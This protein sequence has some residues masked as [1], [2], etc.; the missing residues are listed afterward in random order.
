MLRHDRGGLD[1]NNLEGSLAPIVYKSTWLPLLYDTRNRII[2]KTLHFGQRLQK[3]TVTHR[4]RV[5]NGRCNC[6]QNDT[7][8]NETVFV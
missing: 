3:Y 1:T 2:L 6:I 7:V 5:A 4:F 8:T